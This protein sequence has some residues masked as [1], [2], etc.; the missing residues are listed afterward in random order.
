MKALLIHNDNLPSKLISDFQNTLKFNILHS[1]MIEEGFSFD[2]EVFEQIGKKIE[3]E[4]Y[5]VI[6]LPYSLSNNYLE[7]T[8]LR[9]ALH[10]RLTPEWNHSKIPIVF[11]GHET[12][13]QIAKLSESGNI[14]FTSGIFTMNKFDFDSLIKQYEW[15]I[16]NWRKENDY[17]KLTDKEYESFLNKIKI[18]PPGNYLSHH[19]IDND[20]A[21]LRWSEYT[22]CADKIPEVKENLQTGLY[23]KYEKTLN[24]TSDVKDSKFYLISGEAKILLIDDEAEK[25]W[26]IFYEEFFLNSPYIKFDYLNIDFKSLKQNEITIE[27][28]KKIIEY[29]P[30]VVL[31]DLRLNDTDFK[32]NIRPEEFTGYKIL[33]KI[34]KYNRGIQVI[35]ITASNKVWN[36]KSLVELGA[37]GY[38]IKNAYSDIGEDIKNLKNTIEESISKKYLKEIFYDKESLI[39]KIDDSLKQIKNQ[40]NISYELIYNA[41]NENQFAYAFISLYNVIE[42]INKKYIS[43]VE[44]LKS[45]KWD[46]TSKSYNITDEEIK[47]NTLPEWEK[48]ANIYFQKWK[49]K[50]HTIVKNVYNMIK[51][52]NGFI[53]NDPSIMDKTVKGKYIN[54]DIYS[55][56]GYISLFK[57]IKEIIDSY[58]SKTSN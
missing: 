19:S 17:P 48:F 42:N 20:L 7:L 54:H 2:N 43:N 36:Y 49:G 33:E 9:I 57:L 32:N 37:N 44:T 23:F 10:I 8:G 45:I 27:A 56:E 46:E 35:I 29:N 14:L 12:P 11:I 5:K 55:K 34:K 51:K 53:H 15:I 4:S 6:F 13:A 38:I 1:K 50:N 18:N 41:K 28:E 26:K 31:L 58:L 52:R 21:L 24:P 47:E 30:D 22:G 40:L 16:N 3:Q 25:G 39:N